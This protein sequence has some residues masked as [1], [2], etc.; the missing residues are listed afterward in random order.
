MRIVEHQAIAE[1]RPGEDSCARQV[2]MKTD[3]S[4]R[5][6]IQISLLLGLF[7]PS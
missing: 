2:S 7:V 5:L 3:F 6:I 1:E 4:L